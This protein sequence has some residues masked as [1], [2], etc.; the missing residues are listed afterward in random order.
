MILG[1]LII[2]PPIVAGGDRPFCLSRHSRPPAVAQDSAKAQ[3]EPTSIRPTLNALVSHP[4]PAVGSER[5]TLATWAALLDCI[6]TIPLG[7]G[8]LDELSVPLPSGASTLLAH[9][10]SGPDL[11]SAVLSNTFRALCAPAYP[12]T[13]ASR[14][15]CSSGE[16][17]RC[18]PDRRTHGQCAPSRERRHRASTRYGAAP[19]CG[20]L[21]GSTCGAGRFGS[22]L[23]AAAYA[24][25]DL[26]LPAYMAPPYCAGIS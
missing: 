23:H 1:F 17:A 7:T 24:L 9:A 5:P 12:K 3:H 16:C 19:K 13:I 15:T 21:P 4:P 2:S 11:G 10:T 8:A 22:T 6:I 26:A 18:P 20:I 25:G 14:A